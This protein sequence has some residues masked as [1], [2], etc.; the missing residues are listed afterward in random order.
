MRPS[1]AREQTAYQLPV[2]CVVTG[3]KT[4]RLGVAAG[5]LQ[6]RGRDDQELEACGQIAIAR[7]LGQRI[8]PR[9]G[10]EGLQCDG[11]VRVLIRPED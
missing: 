3:D 10:V 1:Q 5:S 2:R 11:L 4:V 7:A 9:N 6:S 8:E